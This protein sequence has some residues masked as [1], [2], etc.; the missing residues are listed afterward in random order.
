MQAHVYTIGQAVIRYLP[1]VGGKQVNHYAQQNAD[2]Q[3]AE[4]LEQARQYKVLHGVFNKVQCGGHD[5]GHE[6][7]HD[8]NYTKRTSLK[9]LQ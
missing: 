4:R 2:A 5:T 1:H 3:A 6:Q 9:T 8:C 7:A